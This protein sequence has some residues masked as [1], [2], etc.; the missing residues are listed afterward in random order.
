[1]NEDN[2]KHLLFSEESTRPDLL[3]A[4]VVAVWDADDKDMA[5]DWPNEEKIAISTM[6]P[7]EFANSLEKDILPTP[8]AVAPP[9]AC[10]QDLLVCGDVEDEEWREYNWFPPEGGDEASYLITEPKQV[11]YRPNGTTHQVVDSK[12]VTHVV[13]APG[14]YGCTFK[15]HSKEGAPRCK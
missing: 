1:M 8:T 13:P 15:F 14:R 12:G 10:G 7:E 11:L 6:T 4:N 3:G 9:A 5:E 2:L